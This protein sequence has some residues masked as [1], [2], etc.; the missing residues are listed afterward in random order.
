[1]KLG[2]RL[3]KL[4]KARGWTQKELA[5]KVGLTP[6][7]ISKLERGQV[8]QPQEKTIRKLAET[9]EADEEDLMLLGKRVP[10]NL[11]SVVLNYGLSPDRIRQLTDMA[12]R[13]SPLYDSLTRRQQQL[14]A[15]TSLTMMRQITG[16]TQV[17]AVQQ[18]L[19]AYEKFYPQILARVRKVGDAAQFV[20]QFMKQYSCLPKFLKRQ[21]QL[22]EAQNRLLS[23]PLPVVEL[24][25][26]IQLPEDRIKESLAVLKATTEVYHL[27]NFHPFNEVAFK[28]I[29]EYQV[30][31]KKQLASIGNKDE[32]ENQRIKSVITIEYGNDRLVHTGQAW[33]ETA[34]LLYDQ[35]RSSS[36]AFPYTPNLLEVFG[37]EMISSSLEPHKPDIFYK[38]EHLRPSRISD[39]AFRLVHL[40]YEINESCRLTGEKKVFNNT[41]KNSFVV[42]PLL[43]NIVAVSEGTLQEVSEMLYFL[44]YEGSRKLENI[45]G[46]LNQNEIEPFEDVKRLRDYYKHDQEQGREED[47][48]MKY[49]REFRPMF[50]RL[51]SKASPQS[52]EDF[53]HLQI[54]L[55][56]R[57]VGALKQLQGKL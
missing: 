5:D 39:L 15:L 41:D 10:I 19:E 23:M 43:P 18:R 25:K 53:E 11:R 38:R 21:Y 17:E 34:E 48:R 7:Y 13:I 44:L 29:Y 26:T 31:A 16:A 57:L 35:D 2:D 33:K 8:L 27:E 47:I 45:R 28:A 22:V 46:L 30:V 40:L 51:I 49:K 20:S 52:R 42:L 37:D 32:D 36:H 9:L 50:Q 3:K 1:M 54:V 4:R 12:M 6:T 56:E 55:L 24:L 14:E